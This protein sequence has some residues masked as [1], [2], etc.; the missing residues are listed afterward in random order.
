MFALTFK[1]R[2]RE[3][4]S[5]ISL[6]GWEPKIIRVGKNGDPF[7]CGLFEDTVPL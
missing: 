7:L 2:A 4:T 3:L 5:L 1:V 6:G